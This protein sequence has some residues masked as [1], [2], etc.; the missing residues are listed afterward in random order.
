MLKRIRWSKSFFFKKNILIRAMSEFG[1][2]GIDAIWSSDQLCPRSVNK[3]KVKIFCDF[4]LI[5]DFEL[6]TDMSLSKETKDWSNIE[7]SKEKGISQLISSTNQRA[8]L[9]RRRP[10]TASLLRKKEC[11]KKKIG[12]SLWYNWESSLNCTVFEDNSLLWPQRL[13]SFPTWSL[14]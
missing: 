12:F 13:E 2:N 1:Q 14:A 9:H 4:C 5:F 3:R 8:L 10:Q 6:Q 7:I 11:D